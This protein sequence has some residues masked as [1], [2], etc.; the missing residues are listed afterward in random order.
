MKPETQQKMP[1]ND[2]RSTESVFLSADDLSHRYRITK[3]G[4][5][6]WQRQGKLPPADFKVSQTLRW[7]LAAIEEWEANIK[8]TMPGH[9]IN[10]LPALPDTPA[11]D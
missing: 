6:K 4:V 2:T 8:A 7:S 10:C 1:P 9:R 3:A 11:Q 5:W